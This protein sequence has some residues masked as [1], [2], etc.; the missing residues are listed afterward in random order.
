M[1]KDYF[2]NLTSDLYRLTLLFPEGEPLKNKMRSEGDD[3]LKNLLL[4]LRG[5]FRCSKNLV[6]NT[7]K[8]LEVLEGYFK[9]VEDQNWI[10][11]QNLM[12]VRDA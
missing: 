9:I 6:F 12:E 8:K 10:S 3:I 1:D 5:D 7:D 11:P 4:I 2:T